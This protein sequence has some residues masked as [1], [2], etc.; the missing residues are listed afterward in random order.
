VISCRTLGPLDVMVDGAPAPADLLWRKNLALLLYLARAPARRCTREHAIGLLWAD[1]DQAA[2][3]Q[4]LREAVRVL[5]RCLGEAHLR[6]EGD[7]LELAVGA[8]ELDTDRFDRFLEKEDWANA[9]PLVMGEFVEGFAVP[10]ASAF[11]DWLLA[12]RLHWRGRALE[13]L[14]RHAE[15]RLAAGDL[16]GADEPARR[17]PG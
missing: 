11:E 6:T 12:E 9:A 14:V 16:L 10:D 1:K 4:S 5:R 17:A 8:V 13:A 15:D 3:R 2:A 7:Q